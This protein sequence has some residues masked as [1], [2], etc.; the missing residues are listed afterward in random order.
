ML[1]ILVDPRAQ[2]TH[3]CVP[4]HRIISPIIVT[5][6]MMH[7]MSVG[8]DIAKGCETNLVEQGGNSV[9]LGDSAVVFEATINPT[10][11]DQ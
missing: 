7:E 11:V 8:T 5:N 6:V 3:V 9:Q 1:P 4:T 2:V 10:I